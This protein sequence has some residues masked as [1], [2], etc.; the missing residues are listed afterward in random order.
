[1]KRGPNKARPMIV[2][3]RIAG[4]RITVWDVLHYLETG[5]SCPEIAATLHLSAAQVE[6]VAQYIEAHKEELLVVHRHIEER[7]ARGNPP[8]ITA[9]LA[10]SRTKLQEWLKQHHETKT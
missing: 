4:T 3:N 6:A 8:A 10:K 9:K 5:W 1:M 7:K 2:K